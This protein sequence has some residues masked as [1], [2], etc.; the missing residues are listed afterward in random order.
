MR[1]HR[2]I[3]QH[4]TI[5]DGRRFRLASI[6][7]DSTGTLGDGAKERAEALLGDARDRL[8]GLQEK[9]A[10]QNRWSLLIVLQGIDGSGKDSLMEK[11][12]SGLNPAGFQVT[13]FKAPNAAELDHGYLWRHQLALP[14]RGRIGVFNR[15]HYEEVL[16]VKVKPAALAA[17][18]LPKRLVTRKIWAERYE[19]INAWER[20]LTRNGTVVRKFFLHMSKAE[21][22][23]HF[24]ERIDNPDKHWKYNAGDVAERARWEAYTAA[25]E[26]M[27]RATST[28]HAPWIVVPSDHRWFARLVVA[29]AL[30]AA[31][32]SLELAYPAPDAKTREAMAS[33]RAALAA[34]VAASRPAPR[35]KSPSAKPRSGK[36]AGSS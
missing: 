31:L 23:K 24:L 13:S 11:V 32:E 30:V 7:A 16:V 17:Q 9:L 14:Q 10:S 26:T 35:A 29:E 33:Q 18:Q 36:R 15:S 12:F 1:K 4:L 3:A 28:P 2:N 22:A 8:R 5:T 19:D 6:A 34:D 25:F 27:I 21:Q 20:H